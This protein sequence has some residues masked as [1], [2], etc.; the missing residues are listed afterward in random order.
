MIISLAF[1]S[2]VHVDY[3]FVFL[4]LFLSENVDK[5]VNTKLKEFIKSYEI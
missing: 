2:F 3:T 4:Y 1:C 5:V